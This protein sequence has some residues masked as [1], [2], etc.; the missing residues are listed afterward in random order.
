MGMFQV[1][2]GTKVRLIPEG[3]PWHPNHIREFTTTK[4]NIFTKEEVIVD[5]IKKL[6]TNRSHPKTIGGAYAKAGWYG[7]KSQGWNVL[8]H[9]SNVKY[10]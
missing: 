9:A 10:G 7:F 3:K 8:V 2:K 6:G 1:E 5:P 4:V